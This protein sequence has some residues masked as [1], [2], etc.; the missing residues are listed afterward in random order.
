[1]WVPAVVAVLVHPVHAA[2]VGALPRHAANWD[3]AIPTP[4]VANWPAILASFGAIVGLGL[5]NLLLHFG[6]L[7]PSFADYAEWEAAHTGAPDVVVEVGTGS[8][9]APAEAGGQGSPEHWMDY[10]HARRE[11]FKELAFL[12]PCLG[13]ALGG[14]YLGQ[15][16]MTASKPPAPLWLAV[17]SGVLL[18]YLTGGGLVWAVRILGS[19]GFGREAM[20]LGD[21]HLMGAVGAC[22]GW[23]DST[24]AFFG[25]AFVGLAWAI[26]SG[27]SG[28]KLKRMMPYGP[29]LAVSTLLVLLGKPVAERLLSLI[30]HTPIDL[31]P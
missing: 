14:W 31:P 11:M 13:L 19:L 18:G 10:P 17:L 23:I 5:S 27:I 1:M 29:F 21:V 25:A 15:S 6:V 9:V 2:V 4:A 28:G 22:I 8:A 12:A 7:K 16:W 30:F 24:L 3:W 26:L 20:G